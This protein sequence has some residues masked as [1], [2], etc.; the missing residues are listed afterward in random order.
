MTNEQEQCMYCHENADDGYLYEDDIYAI[1][2]HL[3]G[4]PQQVKWVGKN[5]SN[6]EADY[7]YYDEPVCTSE[8]KYFLV[9]DGKWTTYIPINCCPICRRNFNENK[10]RKEDKKND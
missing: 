2:K 1:T 8:E 9:V 10:N 3:Y 7:D 5:I 6:Y 4:K